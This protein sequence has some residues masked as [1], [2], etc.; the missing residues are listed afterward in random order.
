[1]CVSTPTAPTVIDQAYRFALAPTPA[2][3]EFLGAYCGASRFWFTRGL[4][5]LKERLDQRAAGE[6]VEV[7]WSYKQLC[8]AFS[9]PRSVHAILHP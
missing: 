6:D 3:E 1:M 8:S 7:P 4:A 2:Q 5:L 9:R